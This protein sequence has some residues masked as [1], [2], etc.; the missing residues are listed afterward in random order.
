MKCVTNE[1]KIVHVTLEYLAKIAQNVS[2]AF[3]G[4]DGCAEKVDV[5]GK[6]LHWRRYQGTAT[7]RS[8]EIR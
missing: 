4:V 6:H 2:V 3:L 7:R 8:E 1:I 5:P